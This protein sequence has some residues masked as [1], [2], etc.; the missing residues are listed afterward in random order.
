[1]KVGKRFINTIADYFA[2]YENNR[3]LQH[4]ILPISN[5]ARLK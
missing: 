1:M 5:A 4:V 3:C 2:L